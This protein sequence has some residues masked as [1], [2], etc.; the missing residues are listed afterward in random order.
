[1]NKGVLAALT[2]LGI[3]GAGY[4]VLGPRTGEGAM[5][6][7]FEVRVGGDTIALAQFR[8]QV[9]V[10]DFWASW[11]GPC[12]AAMP[13]LERIHQRYAREG[14]VVMGV[15]VNDQ[16]DV[17]KFKQS[18]GASYYSIPSAGGA[19][20]SVAEQ[21]GVSGL[22]TIVVVGKDGT[23]LWRKVGWGPSFEGQ[24]VEAI[25]SELGG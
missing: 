5:A 11:C 17:A 1:M 10:L 7:A 15:Q 6:P 13:A 3:G 4:W 16:A 2:I 24:I 9:V 19:G 25:K 20:D 14:A 8:G 18:M 22:P 21:F 12:R 23:I